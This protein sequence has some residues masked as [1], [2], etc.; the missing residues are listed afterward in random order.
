[1]LE[2]KVS[3]KKIIVIKFQLFEI[4]TAQLEREPKPPRP[5][6][7]IVASRPVIRRDLYLSRDEA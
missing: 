6:R 2:Q 7:N 3:T 5:R 1:M 4:K